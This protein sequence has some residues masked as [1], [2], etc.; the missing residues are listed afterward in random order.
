MGRVC[1]S[2]LDFAIIARMQSISVHTNYKGLKNLNFEKL[3]PQARVKV[4]T[5][6]PKLHFFESVSSAA[7]SDDLI[8]SIHMFCHH[9]N[10][11]G[12]GDTQHWQ[13]PRGAIFR[14]ETGRFVSIFS[15]PCF[16]PFGL[17]RLKTPTKRPICT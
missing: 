13:H 12:V 3:D 15:D 17:H 9:S 14:C 10:P 6:E 1:K 5:F 2:C 11:R 8:G 4:R 7:S 16:N